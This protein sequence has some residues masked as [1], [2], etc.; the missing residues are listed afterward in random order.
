MDLMNTIRDRGYALID[1]LG[2]L[3]PILAISIA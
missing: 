3:I 2:M 1:N